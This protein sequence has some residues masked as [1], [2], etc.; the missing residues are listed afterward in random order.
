MLSGLLRVFGTAPPPFRLAGPRVLLRTP[1]R[2]D[3]QHWAELRGASRGFLTQ[4][5]PSWSP[6]ALT[7]GAFN[8]RLVRYA[9]DWRTDQGYSFLLFRLED[10]ALLGGIGL[11]NVRRGVAETCSLG[12]WIGERYARQ[13]F[14]TEGLQLAL[15]FAFQRA[16][17][18][19]VE[20]ACLP[21]NEASKSLLRRGGFHEEG[22]ARAY[23]CIDG[24]WQDHVL[25]ALLRDG[26]SQSGRAQP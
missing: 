1:E 2:R 24:R 15:T 11:S 6:D 13:G 9:A 4:W 17:L 3:W 18:H 7:H 8:R 20:A 21:H 16:R 5:E 14:I 26:W 23:L 12:Y 19:R 10:D 25:F 22:Y